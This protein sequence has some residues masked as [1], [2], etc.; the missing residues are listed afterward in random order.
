MRWWA[1][2]AILAVAGCGKA[3]DAAVP[4]GDPTAA[5]VDKAVGDT[6]AALREAARTA[7]PATTPEQTAGRTG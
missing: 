3:P 1:T 5:A 2:A 4:G 7:A 6:D